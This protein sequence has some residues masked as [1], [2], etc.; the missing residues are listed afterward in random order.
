MWLFDLC[1]DPGEQDDIADIYPE[2][3]EEFAAAM[4]RNHEESITWTSTT[5]YNANPCCGI[6]VEVDGTD[7]EEGCVKDPSII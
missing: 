1:E 2:I 4:D 6:C 3:V 7:C 5:D